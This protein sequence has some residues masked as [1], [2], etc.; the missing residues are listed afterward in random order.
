MNKSDIATKIKETE[1]KLAAL[2]LE[3]EKP[4]YPTLEDSKSGDML[5]NSCIVVH[6]M[7]DIRMA[8]IAAPE[9]TE[10]QCQ[11]SK[12]FS[13]VFAKLK[14]PGIIRSQW[15]IPSVEQLQLAYKNCA[16]H[17]PAQCYW[18]STMDYGFGLPYS[19]DGQGKI[20]DSKFNSRTCRVFSLVSY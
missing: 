5:Y 19:V 14:H 1:E 18:S 11:W 13:D 12:E 17:F 8:L 6:K 10:I 16:E 7:E 15:F 20:L 3:L 9:S 2:R 4:E